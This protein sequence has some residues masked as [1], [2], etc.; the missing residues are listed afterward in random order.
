MPEISAARDKR[1]KRFLNYRS[2]PCGQPTI[3]RWRNWGPGA[4]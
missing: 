3:S 1:R 2:N 4:R